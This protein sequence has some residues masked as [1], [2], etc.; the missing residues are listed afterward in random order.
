MHTDT[1]HDHFIYPCCACVQRVIITLPC[2]RMC[3]RDKI[4]MFGVSMD[5]ICVLAIYRSLIY[6][7]LTADFFSKLN[8]SS[9]S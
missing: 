9:A 2:A 1:K 3:S 4:I 8:S 5:K 7:V 6:L